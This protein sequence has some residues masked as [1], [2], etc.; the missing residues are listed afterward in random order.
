MNLLVIGNGGREH[1][2]ALKLLKSKCVQKVYCAPGNSGMAQTGIFCVDIESTNFEALIAFAKDHAIA[3]T[4]VGP[5]LPLFEG[6]VDAF[7]AEGL[8]IFGPSQSASRLEG[9]KSF[10]KHLMKKYHIP[11]AAFENYFE[12]EEALDSLKNR[13]YPIVIKADGPAA[14]K[15][16]TIAGNEEEAKEALR[17]IFT[18]EKYGHQEK[19]VIEEYLE[20]PEF[21]FFSL[22]YKGQVLHLPTAQDH[23]RAYEGDKGPN[24]GG[25]GAYA[26]V[27]FVDEALKQEVIDQIVQK[28]LDAMVL[29]G[30]SYQGILYTGL[31]LTAD[32]PKVIEFNCRFGDPETQ[33]L[34]PLL[35][36][37]LA[38]SITQLL[39]GEKASLPLVEGQANFGVVLAAKGYPESPLKDL[40]IP[41]S[42]L[43]GS[44]E[45]S[46]LSY[47][48]REEEG[49]FY[50]EGGR[51]AMVVSMQEDL[52]Q[53]RQ[54]VY[55]YLAIHPISHTFYRQDIAHQALESKEVNDD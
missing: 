33:I 11:T 13:E 8:K 22:V 48:L 3:W 49:K 12:L 32:G 7:E 40:E 51:I 14:G 47:A 17:D 30:C 46:V 44:D 20:G 38:E 2:L 6:I 23:K 41:R 25:M 27:P 55:D 45:V 37:Q 10:A 39:A 19:V 24:T 21:S 36:D 4:I 5:E 34:L 16:V 42:F 9:S 53:A 26:P 43:E 54:V 15:G 31:M 28:T 18:Q 29:E 52:A 35:S 50:S 1:A